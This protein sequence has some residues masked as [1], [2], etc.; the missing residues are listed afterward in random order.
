MNVKTT[1]PEA[2]QTPKAAQVAMRQFCRI[3]DLWRLSKRER[4][5]LLA[6]SA[7]T[8][9]RYELGV[10]QRGLRSQTLERMS[11]I[12]NIYEATKILM[13]D[14]VLAHAW[15]K[16]SNDAEGFHGRSAI[17]VMTEGPDGLKQVW[18]YLDSQVL[19]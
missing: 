12:F 18:V 2:I 1:F 17:A 15:P 19:K 6:V 8:L 7:S 14:A 9:R 4:Q 5:Q 3:A 10:F 11:L 16:R 13:S